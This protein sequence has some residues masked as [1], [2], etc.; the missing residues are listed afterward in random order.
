MKNY[1]I[2]LFLL[3]FVFLSGCIQPPSDGTKYKN[4]IITVEQTIISNS[5]P[6]PGSSTSVS[7]LL[8]NNGDKAVDNV[9]VNFDNIVGLVLKEIYCEDGERKNNGCIFNEFENGGTR[10][11][12]V[13]LEVPEQTIRNPFIEYTISYPYEGYRE[14]SIPVVNDISRTPL[15]KFSQSSPSIGPVLLEFEFPAQRTTTINKQV[16]REYWVVDNEPFEL[17]I[18]IKYV[19]TISDYEPIEIEKN[20][21][22]ID[23]KNNFE[24][25]S[26]LYCAFED[27]GDRLN[28][29]ENVK[30]P[31]DLICNLKS[32]LTPDPEVMASISAEFSYIFQFRKKETLTVKEVLK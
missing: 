23:L 9:E 21:F 31:S 11:I 29:K 17:K 6:Y 1:T 2:L 22:G 24:K 7:I 4:D 32:V 13:N 26:Q 28:P 30:V 25:A 15:G 20:N 10:N 14:A 18:K 12:K 5:N 27:Y 8:K 3:L 19:G 16:I